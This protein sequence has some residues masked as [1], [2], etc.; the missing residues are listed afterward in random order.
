ETTTRSDS[1]KSWRFI[2]IY[3]IKLMGDII[4]AKRSFTKEDI[5]KFAKEENVR[6][7]RLQFTDILGVIK[8][9]EVPVSQL[10]KVLDNQMMFDGS[11]IE[12]FVRIEESDMYLYPDLDTW[13]IFPWT[14][15]QGKVARL[16]C[17]VYKTDG[18]PF[19]GDPR[20]NLKRVLKNMQDLGFSELNL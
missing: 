20:A 3:Q 10:E 9:V 5:H 15:G 18:T 11:S 8:N 16:I 19:E 7:L 13:V 14:A 2:S 6:Y 17:D 4:M 12:G 1:D